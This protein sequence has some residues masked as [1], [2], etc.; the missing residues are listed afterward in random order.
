MKNLFKEVFAEIPQRVIWKFEENVEGFSNNVLLQ[1][2][3]HQ[4]EIL[5]KE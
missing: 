3:V 1:K 5:S 4:K 2:W